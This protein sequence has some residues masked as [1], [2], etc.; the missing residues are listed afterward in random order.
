MKK[1][2]FFFAITLVLAI[3]GNAQNTFPATGSVGIGTTSPNAKS[4]LEVRST[5][6]G[7]LFPRM[8]TAQRNLIGAPPVG[9]LIFQTDGASGFYYYTGS[10]W[11]AVT[12]A[13]ANKTLSN[14]TSPTAVSQSLLPGT[15]GTLDL[16]S[17]SLKWRD[18]NFNGTVY[19]NGASSGIGVE[20][21]GSSYGLYGTGGTYGVYGSG[22]SYGIYGKTTSGYGV[23]GISSSSYGLYGSSTSSWGSVAYGVNGAYGSG[24]TGYG[25]EGVSSSSYGV[26]GSSSSS[27]G[28]YGSSSSSYGVAGISSSGYALYGSSGSGYGLYGSSGS[29][30]GSVAYGT[31]GAYGNGITYGVYGYASG[32]DAKGVY[33]EG[34]AGYGVWGVTDDNSLYYAG[35]FVGD[36]LST[37][38]VYATSDARVK[39]NI[40]DFTSAM[41]IIN[42]LH[43]KQYEFRNDGNFKS[44]NF[45]KGTHYGLIAQ[46]VEKV[47]PNIVKTSELQAPENVSP[48]SKESNMKPDV[49]IKDFKAVNYTELIPLLIKGMQELSKENADL[50][51]Q[52]AQL[53]QMISQNTS[54][55]AASSPSGASLGQN[56]PNPFNKSTVISLSIPKESNAASIVVSQT[57]S[58]KI[59]KSIPVSGASQVTL[60]AASLS[61]GAYT[62]TLYIDGKK[63]DSKQ[64]V[65]SK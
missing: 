16:G 21:S 40:R 31:D 59:L 61:A 6:K 46:D 44:M 9:L 49:L 55:A 17:S 35:Y 56:F 27:Y 11:K 25:V 45:A 65:I 7:V 38:G 13:G 42:Q 24:T 18:G 54:G 57:G 41:D 1:S 22:S 39:Q 51:D 28:V 3:S 29:S 48:G 58:G 23:A 14:L 10:A 15:T 52:V 60:D 19:A 12:A 62:Y 4:L 34:G 47:L 64:M 63:I 43:P 33:G 50:K 37:T 8:T 20:G 2:L 5:T 26:Y 53:K 36:V 30:W 32:A